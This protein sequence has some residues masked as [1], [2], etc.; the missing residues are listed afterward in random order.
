MRFPD[1][2]VLMPL[3]V[4]LLLVGAVPASATDFRTE[5][6][7]V[8]EMTV[9]LEEELPP[10]EKLGTG[11]ALLLPEGSL[12]LNDNRGDDKIGYQTLVGRIQAENRVVLTASL[13]ALSNFDGRGAVM[14]ISRPGLQVSLRFFPDRL[15]LVERQEN[16]DWR[17]MASRSVDLFSEFHEI[18]L[19]KSSSAQEGGERI[20]VWLDGSLVA[21]L[22]PQCSS[23]IPVGRVVIGAMSRP[24][25]GASIWDW[26]RYE[27]DG[28]VSSL[29]TEESSIGQLKAA[30]QA[31]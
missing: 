16:G 30:F 6:S 20:R 19:E 27:L 9:L 31:R 7:G 15:E 29:P 26:M 14:E 5:I 8:Y 23:R 21:D 1:R 25:L 13:K 17:W 12:L 10:W 3:L 24:S 11:A 22:K 18:S 2:M 4:G 28:L